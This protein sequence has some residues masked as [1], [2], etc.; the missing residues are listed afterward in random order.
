MKYIAHLIQ[1]GEGCDYTIG[2]AQTLIQINAKN[3]ADA[4]EKLERKI[5]EEYYDDTEL[6]E[7]IIFECDPYK[8][9]LNH[10]YNRRQGRIDNE[11][12]EANDVRDRAEYD[13]LRQRFENQ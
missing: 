6:Q 13:R 8:I 2:C 7:A 1:R 5:E 10:I 11:R 12:T 9:D 4:V 3:Y